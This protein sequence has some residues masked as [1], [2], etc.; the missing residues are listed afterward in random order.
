MKER[1]SKLDAY[2][3]RLDEW[4]TPEYEG[5]RGMT[6]AQAREQLRQDGCS[7]S[8]SRIGEWW[9]NRLNRK[10]E[11]AMIRQIATGAQVVKDVEKQLEKSSAPNLELIIKLLRVMVLKLTTQA[12]FDPTMLETLSFFLKP[13]IDWEKEQGKKEDRQ[14]AREKW[15]FDAA[16]VC[17]KAL[18]ELKAISNDSR[19]NEDQR[20]EQIRLKLFGVT[21]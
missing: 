14:L 9:G 18:P 11:D 3:E 13:L 8:V 4:L 10:R 19:L 12:N 1:S 5:G 7:V 15:E 16:K 17:L 6:L 21:A 20:I 2:T